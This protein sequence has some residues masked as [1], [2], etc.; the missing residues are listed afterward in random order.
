MGKRKPTETAIQS[1]DSPCLPCKFRCGKTYTSKRCLDKHETWECE[2]NDY[3]VFRS[4]GEK[5][6]PE[7]KK[8]AVTEE[9][10]KNYHT[11]HTDP[12][13]A[14]HL[15]RVGNIYSRFILAQAVKCIVPGFYPLLFVRSDSD[16]ANAIGDICTINNYQLL[17][18]LIEES[19]GFVNLPKELDCD[20]GEKKVN[21]SQLT[22]PNRTAFN[23]KHNNRGFDVKDASQFWKVTLWVADQESCT[24]TENGQSSENVASYDG[25]QSTPDGTLV[26]GDTPLSKACEESG[27]SG[28]VLARP[29]AGGPHRLLAQGPGEAS[30]GRPPPG[31]PPNGRHPPGGPDG[32]PPGGPDGLPPGGPG[33]LPPGGPGG[34]PLADLLLADLPLVDLADRPLVDLSKQYNPPQRLFGLRGPLSAH[35]DD[36]QNP[37]PQAQAALQALQRNFTYQEA[38][39]ILKHAAE[40]IKQYTNKQL[41]PSMLSD[42][43][44]KNLTG[45]TRDQFYDFRNRYVM[46]QGRIFKVMPDAAALTV[47]LKMHKD[48]TYRELAAIFNVSGCNSDKIFWKV[49]EVIF[50]DNILPQR[51]AFQNR[52][53]LNFYF[54][55]LATKTQ[56]HPREFEIYRHLC[57][58]GQRL[59]VAVGDSTKFLL[60]KSSDHKLQRQTYL[61]RL[62]TN[63]ATKMEI[64]DF[65]G[66]TI[67]FFPL[68]ASADPVLGDANIM[69]CQAE[70][71]ENKQ[72]TGGLVRFV[73][74]LPGFVI[75]LI[76]D[77]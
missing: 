41:I 56:Q 48:D 8:Q 44:L 30:P 58:Q 33:G 32:L 2:Y 60:V 29:T 17:K 24:S 11:L 77:K 19:E 23:L 31:R 75:C 74:G 37:S 42:E 73:T 16:I 13:L 53:S 35:P 39:W 43:T 6:N 4:A 7:I 69:V 36:P 62:H 52:K 47:L 15:G 71:E 66:D 1:Q 59:I 5:S 3:A 57:G 10:K 18:R 38:R 14:K 27:G 72:I 55:L 40:P 12:V 67:L 49:M 46:Q 50:L 21:L 28:P 26:F 25:Q 34:L 63:V 64:V 9:E 76:L 54:D 20:I 68:L 70:L 45:L 22:K 51:W 65:D 61:S